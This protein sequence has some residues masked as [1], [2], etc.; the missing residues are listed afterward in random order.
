MEGPYHK[1]YPPGSGVPGKHGKG[2]DPYGFV[3]GRKKTSCAKGGMDS[4]APDPYT[5]NRAGIV[6]RGTAGQDYKRAAGR[7]RDGNSRLWQENLF[8]IDKGIE[9][10]YS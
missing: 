7:I 1:V 4:E 10:V 5:D 6:W 2:K 3:P 8:Y 9:M